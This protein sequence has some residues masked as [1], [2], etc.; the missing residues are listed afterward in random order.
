MACNTAGITAT[1]SKVTEPE[2][3]PPTQVS[4]GGVAVQAALIESLPL[5]VKVCTCAGAGTICQNKLAMKTSAGKTKSSAP[6]P[7]P[8]DKI[9]A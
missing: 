4:G 5:I 2:T 3:L 6:K 1:L 9:F 7:G 8:R